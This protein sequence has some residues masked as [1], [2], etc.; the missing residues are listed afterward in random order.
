MVTYLIVIIMTL[1]VLGV[2]LSQFFQNFLFEEK[3][4]NLI[5]HGQEVNNLVIKYMNNKIS[6]DE[7]NYSLQTLDRYLNARIWVVNP[8]GIVL[9]DSRP[10]EVQWLPL[11]KQEM[12]K[13]LSGQIVWKIGEFGNRFD[14]AVLSVSIPLFLNEKVAGVILLDAPIYGVKGSLEQVYR[15][16]AIAALIA[17]V[18][19]TFL[20]YWFSR[21]ISNPLRRMSE[22]AVHLATGQFQEQVPVE[23]ND[24]IGQL[25]RSFNFMASELGRMEQMRRDFIANVSH[26][27]RSPLTSMR[28]FIQ[29]MLDGTITGEHR[30]R[31]LQI[32]FDET[33]RLTRLVND[34]LDLA[35]MESGKL[36]IELT[37]FNLNDVIDRVIDRLEPQISSRN[38]LMET[39]LLSGQVLVQADRDRIVQVLT[40]LLDNAIRFTPSR[41]LITVENWREDNK[42]YVAI[43]DTGA[44]IPAE[45]LPHI[46]DRFHKADKA[47]TRSKG[48]TGLGLAIVKH[49]IEAHGEEIS[50]TSELNK[51]TRFTFSLAP[52]EREERMQEGPAA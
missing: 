35:R 36:D 50:V 37:V 48:G 31:Y 5:T 24:E 41:Q 13:V 25:A 47:R 40:N 34:L 12:Q 30:E 22:A 11:K 2:L 26:E 10:Y 32:V 8:Q 1:A 23:T 6:S 16:I 21:K 20:T 46:W 45:D 14:L 3:R 42:I 18:F 38:I 33:N 52:F 15:F 9:Q 44:G 7:L 4:K 39:E 29:G 17:I 27:L 49:L 51:G 28:G 19:A 43:T